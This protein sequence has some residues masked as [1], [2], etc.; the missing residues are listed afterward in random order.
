MGQFL[1]VQGAEPV[2]WRYLGIMASFAYGAVSKG[3][4][5][6]SGSAEPPEKGLVGEWTSVRFHEYLFWARL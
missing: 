3:P 6:P 4:K 1:G 2:W 5:G